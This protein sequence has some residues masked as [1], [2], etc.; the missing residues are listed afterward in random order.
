[1]MTDRTFRRQQIDEAVRRMGTLGLGQLCIDDIR[2]EKVWASRPTHI[3]DVKLGAASP[4][5]WRGPDAGAVEAARRWLFDLDAD[6]FPYHYII[7]DALFTSGNTYR[8]CQVL[9][10]GGDSGK[11]AYE[12]PLRQDINNDPGTLLHVWC[13]A[14]NV[15]D[16]QLSDLAL[17]TV[18]SLGGGLLRLA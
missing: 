1:M 13:G 17:V 11:W 16:N 4:F 8:M 5:D 15:T 18:R 6:I 9:Y 2:T 3:F 12:R 14:W 10:V 7:N